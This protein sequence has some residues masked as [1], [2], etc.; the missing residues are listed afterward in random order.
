MEPGDEQFDF[1]DE[2]FEGIEQNGIFQTGQ[3]DGATWADDDECDDLYND[4]NVS[5]IQAPVTAYRS[6]KQEHVGN[7]RGQ[8]KVKDG[9]EQTTGTISGKG[10]VGEAFA[11]SVGYIKHDEI[12][13]VEQGTISG[14]ITEFS[15]ESHPKK[16]RGDDD[17]VEQQ[18]G[19]VKKELRFGH[20]GPSSST[21]SFASNDNKAPKNCTLYEDDE[22]YMQP[23]AQGTNQYDKTQERAKLAVVPEPWQSFPGSRLVASPLEDR[24]SQVSAEAVESNMEVPEVFRGHD[25]NVTASFRESAA[26]GKAGGLNV[27]GG[28]IKSGGD[29]FGASSGKGSTSS[30]AVST[31]NRIGRASSPAASTSKRIGPASI[32]CTGQQNNS[33]LHSG[34]RGT[35]LFVG[36][37]HWW[38]T[39]ADL[40]SALSEYGKVKDI[41]FSE[42]KASG[43]SKGYCQVEFYDHTAAYNCKAGMHGRLFNGRPCVI[44]FS[45]PVTL[46]QFSSAQVNKTHTRH[47]QPSETQTQQPSRRMNDGGGGFYQSGEGRRNYGNMGSGR[48]RYAQDMVG[49]GRGCQGRGRNMNRK[50]MGRGGGIASGGGPYGQGLQGLTG[51]TPIGTMAPHG[52]MVQGFNPLFGPHMARGGGI[53]GGYSHGNPYPGMITAFPAVGA[54]LPGVVPH[55]N[56]VFLCQGPTTNGMGML[57][58]GVMEGNHSAMRI[59]G[60]VGRWVGE[61]QNRQMTDYE[62]DAKLDYGYGDVKH[63]RDRSTC[64]RDRESI[65]EEDA[66]LDYGYSD[67]KHE[68]G[69]SSGKRDRESVYE[70][71]ARLDHGYGDVKHERGRSTGKRGRENIYEDVRLDRGYGGVKHERGRSTG[72]RDKESIYEEDARSDHGYGEVK[73]ERGR[74]GATKNQDRGSNS[75]W[76]RDRYREDRDASKEQRGRDQSW[77]KYEWEKQKHLTRQNDQRSPSKEMDYAKR[78]R[79]VSGRK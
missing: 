46:G 26:S 22:S 24:G 21:T 16:D 6:T 45:S 33:Y 9:V 78:R 54:G 42:E 36:E 67:V 68:R 57:P 64:K 59:D 53:Y 65:Y 39:D 29:N 62:E 38:T 3:T 76:D 32:E 61:D 8:Q 37:L 4:L 55:V 66:R 71:D 28:S 12:N 13:K 31:S 34:V 23:G 75:E 69:R 74:S 50:N 44:A 49:R 51:G 40:E 72:K 5:F 79:L 52:M 18:R 17:E 77:E 19:G 7:G 41:K 35:K 30:P 15:I 43:K 14:N 70:E 58:T 27:G 10:R 56:P 63:E 47:Q 20:P 48:S 60:S 73:H 1:G 11:G 2:D 25:R